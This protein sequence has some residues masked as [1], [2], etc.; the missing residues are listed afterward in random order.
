MHSNIE[1][2]LKHRVVYTPDQIYTIIMNAKVHGKK[3]QVK[4]MM[5]I[6]FYNIKDLIENKNWL[7][8]E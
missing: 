3:H 6:E 7:K 1:R 8:N 5:Q 4:E 2:E